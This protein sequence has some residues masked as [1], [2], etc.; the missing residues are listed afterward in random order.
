MPCV[1]NL[2]DV[3]EFVV[4][5]LNECPF[6]EQNLVV[7]VHKRVLHVLSRLRD[8][9]YVIDEQRLK[10]V[11]AYVAPVGEDF[12]EDP[13]RE[14]LVLQRIA[15]IN[16]TWGKHPLD[17]LPMIVYDDVQLEAVEPSHRAFVQRAGLKEQQQVE[18]DPSLAFH[19][20]VV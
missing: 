17:Y 10:E 8:K 6:S 2:A 9:M 19:E 18:A 7:K 1:L 4:D 3:F 12:S 11:L 16:V 5:G 14:L 15:V 20:T 13:L